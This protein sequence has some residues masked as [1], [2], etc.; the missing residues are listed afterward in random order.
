MMNQ[1]LELIKPHFEQVGGG[2]RRGVESG[3]S[4]P[5]PTDEEEKEA[6]VALLCVRECEPRFH[7]LCMLWYSFQW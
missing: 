5:L 6:A 2:T 4:S 7:V 3:T 1:Y